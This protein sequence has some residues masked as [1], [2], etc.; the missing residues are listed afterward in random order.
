MVI[1][2]R[3]FKGLCLAYN[4]YLK[5][6]SPKYELTTKI[7]VLG[8]VLA[9]LS[10][11]KESKTHKEQLTS[12]ENKRQIGDPKINHCFHNAVNVLDHCYYL[13]TNA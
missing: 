1:A 5:R 13:R 6:F 4:V 12:N 11:F 10:C 7:R 9:I 2:N 3:T 8:G